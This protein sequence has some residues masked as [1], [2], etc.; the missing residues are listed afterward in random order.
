[1]NPQADPRLA[2]SDDFAGHAEIT[3][4]R[5]R[6]I[7]SLNPVNLLGHHFGMEEAVTHWELVFRA[8]PGFAAPLPCRVRRLLKAA[9]RAYGLKCVRARGF[10]DERARKELGSYFEKRKGRSHA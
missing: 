10:D 9:L 5:P 1:M 2:D 8:A 3:P 7:Q 6:P 4:C